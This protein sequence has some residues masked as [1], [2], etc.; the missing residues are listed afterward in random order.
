MPGNG[1][2]NDIG[3]IELDQPVVIRNPFVGLAKLPRATDEPA[4]NPDCWIAGWGRISESNLCH[5]IY[6]IILAFCDFLSGLPIYFGKCLKLFIGFVCMCW[7]FFVCI[8]SLSK[9]NINTLIGKPILWFELR[10][11]MIY[12]EGMKE[13]KIL[14]EH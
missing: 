4:G 5:S 12:F 9:P 2:P 11:I 14:Y 1:F 8:W 3:L 13:S 6:S 10:T 7:F